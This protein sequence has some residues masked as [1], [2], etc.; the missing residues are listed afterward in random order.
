M[1]MA[2]VDKLISLEKAL[3]Y[4]GISFSGRKHDA[5]YDARN[6]S[7][8]FV[9]SRTSDLTKCM[10]FIRDYMTKEEEKVTLGDMFNFAVF[11]LQAS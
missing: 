7:R 11:G 2:K 8:L 5:L 10:N 6:T 1:D 4:C 9:E 3:N